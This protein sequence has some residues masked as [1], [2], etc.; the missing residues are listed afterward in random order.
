[1]SLIDEATSGAEALID[2]AGDVALSLVGDVAYQSA[3]VVGDV[4]ERAL[5][6]AADTAE[7]AVEVV[8]RVGLRRL[9]AVVVVL[10]ILAVVAKLVRGA[11]SPAEP[12]DTTFTPQPQSDSSSSDV[13]DLSA[14]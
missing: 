3:E 9:L 1:M 12:V 6:V 8:R 7:E 5:D 2:G 4:A 10:G 11:N 13:V 14:G